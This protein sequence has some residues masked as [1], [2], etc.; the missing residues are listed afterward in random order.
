MKLT[1]EIK[2]ELEPCMI[3]EDKKKKFLH[4]AKLKKNPPV[5]T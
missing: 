1:G 3:T 2:K 4:A 5:R